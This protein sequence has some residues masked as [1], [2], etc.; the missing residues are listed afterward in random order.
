MEQ[1]ISSRKLVNIIC[2]LVIVTPEDTGTVQ[3]PQPGHWFRGCS[4]K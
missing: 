1:V 4:M 2:V 3:G